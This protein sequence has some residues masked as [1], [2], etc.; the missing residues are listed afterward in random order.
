M[1][2]G[3]SA[4]PQTGEDLRGRIFALIAGVLFG[5]G[6]FVA[7]IHST[8]ALQAGV[9]Q[10]I[11]WGSAIAMA[12]LIAGFAM[13]TAMIL[14]AGSVSTWTLVAAVVTTFILSFIWSHVDHDLP[15]MPNAVTE[16]LAW[17]PFIGGMLA[18]LV[19]GTYAC[20]SARRAGAHQANLEC[21][22]DTVPLHPRLYIRPVPLR[23]SW[24]LSILIALLCVVP[25]D[26]AVLWLAR[27]TSVDPEQ[28]LLV[29]VGTVAAHQLAVLVAVVAGGVMIMSAALS[30]S[31]PIIASLLFMV[32]P[33][34]Y[35]SLLEMFTLGQSM[36]RAH[37]RALT[38]AA[39][40]LGVWGMTIFAL[41]LCVTIAR[42]DGH[43]RVLLHQEA[44]KAIAS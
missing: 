1:T 17:S 26:L 21:A 28:V 2:L 14:T 15:L 24:G 19:G 32:A 29:P 9:T 16:Q 37:L 11:P 27:H 34:L 39:P 25:L 40:V 8:A 36:T 23:T 35:A 30:S 20:G 5:G 12:F 6:S 4:L 7:I 43:T 41:A 31:G 18:S 3:D 33:S 44:L 22:N 38:L 13:V 10:G 42:R